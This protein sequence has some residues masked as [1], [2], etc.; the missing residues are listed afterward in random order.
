LVATVNKTPEFSRREKSRFIPLIVVVL[1]VRTILIFKA[2]FGIAW[3]SA[4]CVNDTRAAQYSWRF[5]RIWLR[6]FLVQPGLGGGAND[7]AGLM[8]N[9]HQKT[10]QIFTLISFLCHFSMII[11]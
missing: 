11:A 6:V 10:C 4:C 2:S 3:R 7:P 5:E 1:L 9:F 8:T